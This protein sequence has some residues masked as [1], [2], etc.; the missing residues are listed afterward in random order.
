MPKF[1]LVR[2]IALL[3]VCGWNVHG[4]AAE[5][6]FS[7]EIIVFEQAASAEGIASEHWPELA[8]LPRMDLALSPTGQGSVRL[9]GSNSAIEPVPRAELAYGG[10]ARLLRN[11]GYAPLLHIGW[12]TPG[13][14][15]GRAVPVRF[16]GS[17]NG[18]VQGTL[19]V[20]L[21]RYLHLDAHLIYKRS[22]RPGATFAL[23]ERRRV[24]SQ[25]LHYFDH[26]LFGML[27]RIL[28][29]QPPDGEYLPSKAQPTPP[30][31]APPKQSQSDVV[32]PVN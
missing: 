19:L 10:T 3:L 28:P 13:L 14:P 27:V 12:R 21:S 7:V 16:E 6:W 18:T 29:Y 23:R 2:S 22:D 24:R 8:D 17:A 31:T 1:N 26:P 5:R 32:K 9:L 25:E 15:K 20:Y 30:Q 11:R 4:V